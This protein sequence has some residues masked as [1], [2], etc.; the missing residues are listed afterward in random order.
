MG[1][2]AHLSLASLLTIASAGVLLSAPA[3]AHAEGKYD[4]VESVRGYCEYAAS[5]CSSGV[6]RCWYTTN[7]CQITNIQCVSAVAEPVSG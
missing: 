3:P 4:C 2:R 5:F 6:A 7:P 1:I